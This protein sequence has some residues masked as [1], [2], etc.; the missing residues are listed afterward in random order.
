MVLRLE[1]MAGEVWERERGSAPPRAGDE[2]RRASDSSPLECLALPLARFITCSRE[3]SSGTGGERARALLLSSSSSSA[4]RRR[5]QCSMRFCGPLLE[6]CTTS[7]S[8]VSCRSRSSSDDALGDGVLGLRARQEER[9]RQRCAARP[10]ARA[11]RPQREADEK[12]TLMIELV[13]APMLTLELRTTSLRSRT[14]HSRTRP[15]CTLAPFSS[16]RSRRGC[17][18]R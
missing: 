15:T 1:G 5:R 7:S 11:E 8:I 16:C 9:A 6:S 17:E 13:A 3:Q 18:Q 2:R 10:D 12:R 14:G 4:R